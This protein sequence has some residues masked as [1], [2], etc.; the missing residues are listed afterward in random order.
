MEP[1]PSLAHARVSTVDNC[2]NLDNN[3]TKSF[4]PDRKINQALNL[5]IGTFVDL[6]LL[7]SF[8]IILKMEMG[9]NHVVKLISKPI[10]SLSFEIHLILGWTKP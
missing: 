9:K 10:L 4:F 5:C 1:D 2:T 8:I 3:Y 6:G 7:K